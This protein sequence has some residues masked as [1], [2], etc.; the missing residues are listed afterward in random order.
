[1]PSD[2][3]EKQNRQESDTP[4][5][6]E[7]IEINISIDD[8]IVIENE[9]SLKRLITD[10]ELEQS[11]VDVVEHHLRRAADVVLKEYQ[12]RRDGDASG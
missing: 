10:H 4:F 11:D 2:E 3:S 7:T 9:L 8:Q 5:D 1:M 12:R 6:F